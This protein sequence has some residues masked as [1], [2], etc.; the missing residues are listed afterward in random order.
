MNIATG[1]TFDLRFCM[2]LY[3]QMFNV[4]GHLPHWGPD[5][6][7]LQMEQIHKN[8]VYRSRLKTNNK[9]MV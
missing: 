6:A 8:I 9:N 4:T 7:Q 2:A 1:F 5:D 3:S